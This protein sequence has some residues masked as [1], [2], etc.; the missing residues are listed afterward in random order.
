MGRGRGGRITCLPTR[1]V[2]A[3][4]LPETIELHIAADGRPATDLLVLPV[5][6]TEH[7]S[8]FSLLPQ[9]VDDGGRVVLSREEIVAAAKENKRLFP[10]DFGH[11]EK[12]GTGRVELWILGEREL[13][14]AHAAHELLSERATFPEAYPERLERG[15]AALERYA[16]HEVVVTVEAG[17]ADLEF[18]PRDLRGYRHPRS[19]EQ[20]LLPDWPLAE[21]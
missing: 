21:S 15:E 12:H 8:P 7:K 4:E 3:I 14:L 5:F 20:R 6:E 10:K 1:T 13:R 19:Y 2:M 9:P 17:E 18:V 16:D 11:L